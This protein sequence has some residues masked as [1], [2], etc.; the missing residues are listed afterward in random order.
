MSP[1]FEPSGQPP[2]SSAL[3]IDL[4]DPEDASILSSLRAFPSRA[5]ATDVTS[6]LKN[7]QDNLEFQI[8]QFADGMHKLEQSRQTMDAVASK[9][10]S[11]SATRLDERA[12]AEKERVGTAHLPIQ[13]V[14]RTLSRIMPEGNGTG[15]GNSGSR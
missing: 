9:V 4:L 3:S 15:G 8:D 7:I 11:L 5:L 6:R 14:L 10:L 1:L 13:E 12:A 2:S